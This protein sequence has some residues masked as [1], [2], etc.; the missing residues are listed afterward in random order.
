[1]VYIGKI[2]LC[3]THL[4]HHIFLNY[5]NFSHCLAELN[6]KYVT[7]LLTHLHYLLPKS[8]IKLIRTSISKNSGNIFYIVPFLSPSYQKS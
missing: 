4:F 8:H 2:K 7:I 6:F 5:I 1:M 3:I